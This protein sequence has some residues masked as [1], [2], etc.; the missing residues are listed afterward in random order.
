V[1]IATRR[2]AGSQN[3]L[4]IL[5]CLAVGATAVDY[6]TWRFEVTN[7]GG[8][9]IAAPLLAAE[10]F[11]ALHTV[12][13][14]YTV[15]PRPQQKLIPT[16]DPTWRPIFILIPTVDEGEAVLEPTIQA[17]HEARRRYLEAY[18]KGRVSI[19]VCNDGRV[20]NAATWGETES[21]ARRLGVTCVTRTV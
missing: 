7:W 18:P 3:L 20:A 5:L 1:S 15:W 11:G 2:S 12:G 9:W 17:A 19:V 13:L 8:W 10:L 21:L 6:L 16:E 14:Q 4:T